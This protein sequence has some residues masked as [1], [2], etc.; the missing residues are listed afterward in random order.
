MRF[1]PQEHRPFFHSEKVNASSVGKFPVEQIHDIFY[2]VFAKPK[3][4]Y[5]NNYIKSFA[6]DDWL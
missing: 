2:I 1:K 5:S 6:R 3:L 4:M